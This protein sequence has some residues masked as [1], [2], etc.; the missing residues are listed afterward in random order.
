M[1]DLRDLKLTVTYYLQLILFF[2]GIFLLHSLWNQTSDHRRPTIRHLSRS[3]RI[4]KYMFL[5]YLRICNWVIGAMLLCKYK[6]FSLVVL[7]NR[8]NFLGIRVF[9]CMLKFDLILL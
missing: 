6:S 1:W 3:K 9:C 7:L 2:T 8:S 5:G 4:I